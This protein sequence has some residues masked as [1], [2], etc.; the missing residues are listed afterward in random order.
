MFPL[1]SFACSHLQRHPV[2]VCYLIRG[3]NLESMQ[4]NEKWWHRGQ[5]T[6]GCLRGSSLLALD[7]TCNHCT[8]SRRWRVGWPK[9]VKKGNC[10]K[11]S[12]IPEATQL[13][14][15]Q[16]PYYKCRSSKEQRSPAAFT[17][18][19]MEDEGSHF[20]WPFITKCICHTVSLQLIVSIYVCV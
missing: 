18:Q 1:D 8:G 15:M 5:T 16:L 4:R 19:N 20:K 17:L 9:G 12:S 14:Y 11:S 3:W 13:T 10:H 7:R 6:E 2:V